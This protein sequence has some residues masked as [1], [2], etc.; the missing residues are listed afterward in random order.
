MMNIVDELQDVNMNNNV[1]M[2]H[3]DV[4][5]LIQTERRHSNQ[6]TLLYQLSYSFN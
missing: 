4:R 5:T 6:K 2:S 1:T 3:G